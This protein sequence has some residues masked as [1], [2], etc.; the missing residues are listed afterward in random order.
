MSLKSIGTGVLQAN[1]DWQVNQ[2]GKSVSVEILF[3]S[4][5]A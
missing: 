1:E 2:S 5:A 4:Y 3:E